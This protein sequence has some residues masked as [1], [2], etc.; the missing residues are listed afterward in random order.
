VRV[1]ALIVAAGLGMLTVACG[2]EDEACY[3]PTAYTRAD[4]CTLLGDACATTVGATPSLS[5]PLTVVPTDPASMP[6]GVT[7]QV[8]HNNLD[9][10]WHED[11]LYFAFRTAP[12]HFASP[13][14]RMYV[15]STQDQVTWTLEATL[16][17]NT[18]LRE[19]RFLSVG[20][21]LYLYYALLGQNPAAFEPQ[22]AMFIEREGP[23]GWT[24]PAPFYP[25]VPGFIP[26]RAKTVG[27][28]AYVIG[29]EGGENIYVPGGDPVRVHWL[30]TSDGRTFSP[31]VAGQPVM[32]TGG[33]SETDLVVMDDGSVVAVARNELGDAGGWGSKICRGEA[34]AP[35]TWT[36]ASDKR[37]YDSP[38]VF[39]HGADVWMIA[40]RQIDNGGFYDLEMRSLT[41]EQQTRVYNQT[42][43]LGPKRCAL[44]RVD[45]TALTATF[46]MDLPS[47]G[48]T[49][50][51]GVVQLDADRYLVY[52]YSSPF[53]P[54]DISW[55]DGQ[56][57]PTF[58]YRTTLTL[59]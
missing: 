26:W 30:T 34:S 38:I 11:R 19:P 13:D 45:G 57:G 2:G 43:W 59:P 25:E 55:F 47:A 49:C 12:N 46:E 53:E 8:S 56:F 14:V 50:F 32:L 6:S 48:D 37:K 15:V 33:A 42:Y 31:A 4:I 1:R 27:D 54:A 5:T 9:I 18:D 7:S 10:V 24:D 29:Y 17:H 52:N 51:P 35:G 28:T 58:I 3:V 22:G 36:C 39:R 40:R 41:P 21:R 16:Y 44:W 23:C 20:G